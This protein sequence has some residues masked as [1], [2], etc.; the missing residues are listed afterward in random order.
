MRSDVDSPA[1]RLTQLGL[2]IALAASLQVLETILPRPA[3]WLRLGLGNA[4]VLVALLRWGVREAVWV[5]V[6]KVLLG[7]L[8]GGTLF[9]PAF[10]LAVGGT[11]AAAAVMVV[12]V[13]LAPPL[14]CA[15][16]SVFGSVAHVLT[17]LALARYI[18]LRSP[19]L[20]AL[21]PL[22]GSTAVL[23][24]CITGVLAH[25]VLRLLA[26]TARTSPPII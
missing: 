22:L 17:Q 6:G 2:L 19:A 3:P 26:P 4:L 9:G 15:G 18:V 24:G 5:A 14:G 8:L 13:R 1:S 23:S 16:I 11:S 25:R 10:L 12:A 7:G 21:A 20:W